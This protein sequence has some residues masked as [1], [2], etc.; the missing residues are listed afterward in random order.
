MTGWDIA[1]MA[2]AGYL[3]VTALIRLTLRRREQMYDEIR[4]HIK[5]K[6]KDK[7]QQSQLKE[8]SGRTVSQTAAQN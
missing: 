8:K 1:L 6:D 5:D 3:A 7:E 4:H 2:V